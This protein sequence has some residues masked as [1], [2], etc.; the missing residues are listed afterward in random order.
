MGSRMSRD[1]SIKLRYREPEQWLLLH[2]VADGRRVGNPVGSVE[3]GDLAWL[4]DEKLVTY[5][6]DKSIWVLTDKGR[7]EL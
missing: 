1:G 3:A 4:R 2:Q 5:D 6:G 7:N